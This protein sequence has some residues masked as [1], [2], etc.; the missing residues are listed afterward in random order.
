MESPLKGGGSHPSVLGGPVGAG[1]GVGGA[2]EG[3]PAYLPRP[4]DAFTFF[5]GV[6]HIGVTAFDAV[7]LQDGLVVF[8]TQGATGLISRWI[9]S[10]RESHRNQRGPLAKL[11]D[12]IGLGA[13][14]RGHL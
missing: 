7:D 5:G 1:A 8:E 2:P 3:G 11:I 4:V 12:V 6:L 14:A 9:A 13:D 10:V